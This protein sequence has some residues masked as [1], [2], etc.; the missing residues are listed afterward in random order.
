M[1]DSMGFK[2]SFGRA[3]AGAILFRRMILK[4]CPDSDAEPMIGVML[5]PGVPAALLN[6]GIS[7]AGRVPVNLNYTASAKAVESAIERCGLRSVFTSEK[8]TRSKTR[9][10]PPRVSTN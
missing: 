2:L 7:M 4:R 6:L 8:P 9:S 1:A 5:P 10:C 3:L